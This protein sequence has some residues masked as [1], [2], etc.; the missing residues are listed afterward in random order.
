VN[1]TRNN[2]VHRNFSRFEMD[3]K[4]KFWESKV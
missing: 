4:L 2:F 3:L 1:Q